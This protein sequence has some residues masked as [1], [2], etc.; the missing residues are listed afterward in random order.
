MWE[1]ISQA[2]K[3]LISSKSKEK[4]KRKK[5]EGNKEKDRITLG[6]LDHKVIL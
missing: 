3:V 6:L 5:K 2:T 4:E 1:G